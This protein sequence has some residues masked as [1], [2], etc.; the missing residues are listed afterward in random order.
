MEIR[1]EPILLEQKS[2]FMQLMN[3]CNYDSTEYEDVDINEYGYYNYT[4]IDTLWND[5]NRHSYFIRVDDKLAGFVLVHNR[6]RYIENTNAHNIDEFFVMK[7]YRKKGV[8]K[9]AATAVFNL[10]QVRGKFYNSPT[11]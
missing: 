11:T 3:L 10:F 1:I 5:N 9:Y 2:V 6:C 4:N 8:G 7:K